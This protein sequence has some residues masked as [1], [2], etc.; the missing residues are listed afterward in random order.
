MPSHSIRHNLK[1]AI[2]Q[3]ES[4]EARIMAA[5]AAMMTTSQRQALFDVLETHI[6]QVE[7]TARTPAILET[8]R[9]SDGHTFLE[10]LRSAIA[11][12]A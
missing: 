5:M 1:F 3:A 9:E 6:T 2:A 4:A 8:I 12:T 10:T 11:L 7:C